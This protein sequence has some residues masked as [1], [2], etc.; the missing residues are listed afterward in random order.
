MEMWV[1]Y[2]HQISLQLECKVCSRQEWS[3]RNC[4]LTAFPVKSL[5]SKCLFIQSK[6]TGGWLVST[7]SLVLTEADQA[8]GRQTLKFLTFEQKG[9]LPL[10]YIWV[11]EWSCSTPMLFFKLWAEGGV[12]TQ[13]G[14]IPTGSVLYCKELIISWKYRC[15][16]ESRVLGKTWCRLQLW[17]GFSTGFK[18]K[19]QATHLERFWMK[20]LLREGGRVQVSASSLFLE[21]DVD[22]GSYWKLNQSLSSEGNLGCPN[23]TV[24]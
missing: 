1:S 17:A 4:T 18:H 9:R 10:N 16:N 23:C 11:R 5:V 20:Q 19:L 21:T 2:L 15:H 14:L 3:N 7:I 12:G 13:K 8:A 24:R 6:S 22:E